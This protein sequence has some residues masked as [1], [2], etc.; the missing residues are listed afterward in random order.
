MFSLDKNKIFQDH[1]K[2]GEQKKEG[3]TPGAEKLLFPP[4]YSGFNQQYG[5]EKG[6]KKIKKLQGP[7][8]EDNEQDQK[9]TGKSIEIQASLLKSQKYGRQQKKKQCDGIRQILDQIQN[10]SPPLEFLNIIRYLNMDTLKILPWN[11][12]EILNFCK[13]RTGRWK[14]SVRFLKTRDIFLRFPSGS[15]SITIGDRKKRKC[16]DNDPLSFFQ[17]CFHTE[18]TK[19]LHWLTHVRDK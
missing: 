6:T 7:G 4:Q 1:G 10:V 5:P 11:P 9:R 19:G 8:T 15:A 13:K 3:K 14:L 17:Q 16:G 18:P 2:K 12:K